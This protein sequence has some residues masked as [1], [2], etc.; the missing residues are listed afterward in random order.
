MDGKGE[1][2]MN[3]QTNQSNLRHIL[4]AN[5]MFSAT[6]GLIFFLAARPLAQF[7]GTTP[8]VMY[9][10]ATIMFGYAAL[11]AFNT[12]ASHDQPRIYSFHCDW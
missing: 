8:L 11:I 10:L 5:A 4:N 6:S 7:L 2:K 3:I 1:N 12:K 9:I